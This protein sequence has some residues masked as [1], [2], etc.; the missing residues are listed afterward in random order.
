MFMANATTYYE[1]TPFRVKMVL[2]V[3]A[4]MNM[5]YFQ[6]VTFRSVSAWDSSR[7]PAAA[8]LAGFISIGLWCSVIGFGRWIGFVAGAE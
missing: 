3:L 4:G 7:P 6:K 2:L 1:N 8:R 5:L